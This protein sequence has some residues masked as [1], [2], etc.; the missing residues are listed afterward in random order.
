MPRSKK[1]R[2][3]DDIDR[4]RAEAERNMRKARRNKDVAAEEHAL[5]T[6]RQLANKRTALV[7]GL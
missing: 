4:E 6:L 5:L 3:I 1:S 2:A 7:N